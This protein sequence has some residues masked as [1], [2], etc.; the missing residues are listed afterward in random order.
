MDQIPGAVSTSILQKKSFIEAV[1]VIPPIIAAIIVVMI[2]YPD[3]AKRYIVWVSLSAVI[4]LVI[5]SVLRVLHARHQDNKEVSLKS[6]EGLFG[7]MHVLYAM[8]SKHLQYDVG[9]SG[10]L[11]I[12][13]HRV[14]YELGG[15][16]PIGLQQML[17]YIG[18]SGGKAGRD[19]S[20]NPG[21]IGHVAR[22]GEVRV[23]SRVGDHAAFVK[24]LV[25]NWFYTE[26]EAKTLTADRKTWMAV[27][28]LGAN[29]KVLV[30]IYLDSA[31][32]DAF[33]QTVIE[34]VVNGCI[35]IAAYISEHYS[36]QATSAVLAKPSTKNHIEKMVEVSP[37][38]ASLFEK[39]VV[40]TGDAESKLTSTA[41]SLGE[42]PVMPAE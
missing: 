30:V 17:P 40:L 18:G 14:K 9:D 41:D 2:N 19:F 10:K 6:Y 22:S 20:I 4:W 16:A 24:D 38:G 5:S 37:Q 31:E 11:R 29:K 27:P 23:A 12:T 21:I 3:P 28:V 15:D 34:L 39:R 33:S 26:A 36:L 7:A 35:G 13:M 1:T 25:S 8:L 32:Q 42:E